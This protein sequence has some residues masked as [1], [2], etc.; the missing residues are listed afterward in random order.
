M[1]QKEA[2]YT[3]LSLF[4]W[5]NDTGQ[6]SRPGRQCRLYLKII[7]VKTSGSGIWFY[8]SFRKKQ[9]EFVSPI[10]CQQGIQQIEQ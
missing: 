3:Q 1:R 7:S 5:L 8:V 6:S 10:A 2:T 4:K 9:R